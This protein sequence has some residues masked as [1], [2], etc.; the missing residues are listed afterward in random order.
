M[1]SMTGYGRGEHTQ[2]GYK[3]ATE[4]SSVNRRQSEI[5]VYLPRELEALDGRVRTEI[6]RRI[7]RGRVT[8]RIT[9]QVT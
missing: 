7:A 3:I 2:E 8:A 1:K 9:L 5:N 4:I 6:N